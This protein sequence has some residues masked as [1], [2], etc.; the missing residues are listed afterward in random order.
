MTFTGKPVVRPSEKGFIEIRRALQNVWLQLR[1]IQDEVDEQDDQIDDMIGVIDDLHWED[2]T[3]LLQEGA[4]DLILSEFA[5]KPDI[6]TM[7]VYTPTRP[8]A[9]EALQVDGFRLF[10]T[11]SGETLSFEKDTST[12]V[13]TWTPVAG[14]TTESG[15][16]TGEYEQGFYRD[17]EGL[18]GYV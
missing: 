6:I 16:V 12:V 15:D 11:E 17:T 18:P 3:G 10:V 2:S 5:P 13:Y 9:F 7:E 8:A 4:M 14:T 1:K